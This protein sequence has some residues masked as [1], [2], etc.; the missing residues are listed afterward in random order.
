MWSK[1]RLSAAEPDGVSE[2]VEVVNVAAEVVYGSGGILQE[3]VVVGYCIADFI[4]IGTLE[5]TVELIGAPVM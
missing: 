3:I 4:S 5:V 2:G 1:G